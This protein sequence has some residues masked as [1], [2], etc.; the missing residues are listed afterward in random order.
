MPNDGLQFAINEIALA[1]KLNRKLMFVGRGSQI[2]NMITTYGGQRA[3]CT[4]TGSGFTINSIYERDSTNTTWNLKK[5]IASVGVSAELNSTPITDT[6][7][8]T[9]AGT[10]R[11]VAYTFPTT[12]KYNIITGIEWKNGNAPM[13]G[14]IIAGVDLI[15]AETP[16]LNASVLVALSSVVAQSGPDAVQRN[17]RIVS[18]IIRG[19]TICGLW[20]STSVASN[21]RFVA[22]TSGFAKTIAYTT[23]PLSQDVSAFTTGGNPF[24]IKVYYV[25]YN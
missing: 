22:G 11:F 23:S 8:A 18:D 12:Y 17:S 24:Y 10:R 19:G 25:G 21:Q 4:E 7:T 2:S 13:S 6:S 20:F 15:D 3:F 9:S 5:S 16:T 1:E 14:D